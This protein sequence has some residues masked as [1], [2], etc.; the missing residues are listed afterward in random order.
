[1]FVVFNHDGE[2]LLDVSKSGKERP[3]KKHKTNSQL[4][5]ESFKR[6]DK[7]NKATNVEGCGSHLRFNVCPSGHEKRLTWANFCRV[8]LCPMC[9]WRRSLLIAHQLKEVAHEAVKQ[10]PLRWLFLT[11]TVRNCEAKD[12]QD[13]L[14]HMMESWHRLIRRK[15]FKNAIVGWF[16]GLEITRNTFEDT[17]HPHFH[18]LLAVEPN[19]FRKKDKYLTKDDFAALWQKSLRVDYEPIVDIRI[20]KNKRNPEKEISI[21]QEK[22]VELGSDG[23]VSESELA[24]S[25]VAE[26]AKYATKADDFLVYNEYRKKQEGKKVVLYPDP[27]SGLNEIKTDEVVNVLDAGLSRRRL[28]AFGGFL[29]EIWNELQEKGKVQDAEDDNADLVHVE[30]E[31]NCKCSVCGSDMLEELYSW[32]PNLNNYVKK[33]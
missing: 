26:L 15:P 10:K 8:R 16:R 23:A 28:V 33:E 32:L 31:T 11:L 18:V 13:N 17:Y 5:S 24:G 2:I 20:V 6:L 1:M 4:L 30:G 19:Y 12:L 3:W 21:L 14:T 9:S 22:G 27:R 7:V 29:K 25:A